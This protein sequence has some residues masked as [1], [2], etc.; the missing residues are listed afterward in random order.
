[1]RA[2]PVLVVA[3]TLAIL[4]GVAAAERGSEPRL[5]R[6]HRPPAPAKEVGKPVQPD[7]TVQPP[8]GS[9]GSPAPAPPP[10]PTPPPSPTPLP[11]TVA[12]D[13]NEYSIALSR[14]LVG[15]GAVTFNVYN[16]GM[17]EHDLAVVDANGVL[18]VASVP[19]RESRSFVVQ[20][21]AGR[22]KIYCSLFG[23][24]PASHEA[25]GMSAFVDVG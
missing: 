23:G 16:R 4:T 8:G 17:D 13:E 25:L 6:L 12:V 15:E 11:R 14:T 24:T 22:V 10:P 21:G 2:R 7:P 3:G 5:H 19:S 1:M 20:L 9:G 18:Q